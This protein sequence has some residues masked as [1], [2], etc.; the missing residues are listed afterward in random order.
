[1]SPYEEAMTGFSTDLK[2]AIDSRLEQWSMRNP[3]GQRVARNISSEHF[4]EQS[5]MTELLRYIGE[6]TPS[7]PPAQWKE[8]ESEYQQLCYRHALK[9]GSIII[10]YSP[11]YFGTSVEKEAFHKHLNDNYISL[12]NNERRI[13]EFTY[14]LTLG[15][16]AK[17]KKHIRLKRY[18]VWSTWNDKDSK[19]YPYDYCNTDRADEVRACMGLRQ[20]DAKTDLL[21]FVYTLPASI[22]PMR[23]TIADAELSEYFEP[24]AL[25]STISHTSTVTW[26]LVDEY[27]KAGFY[28]HPRPE[29]VHESITFEE[30]ILPVTVKW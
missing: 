15:R 28:L 27:E 19:G 1:M 10:N 3:Y 18:S 13:E 23:A 6:F 29:C 30:I 21:I 25:E 26:K 4:L 8:F 17:K 5:S 20:N 16:V 11:K 7:S 12:L 24:P 22:V 14:R 9:G 2:K